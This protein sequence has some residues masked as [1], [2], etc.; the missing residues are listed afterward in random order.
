MKNYIKETVNLSVGTEVILK[1]WVHV[2]RRMGK[3][4]FI[5]LRDSTGI[6]QVVCKT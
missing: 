4:G 5:E 3:L 6:V 1:G 2:Y